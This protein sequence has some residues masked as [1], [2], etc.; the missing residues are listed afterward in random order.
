MGVVMFYHLTASGMEE[1]ARALLTRSLQA[2]WRVMLRGTDAA[3]LE[4]L[5]Q[6]LW[7]GPAESFLPHGL[8]GG[9]HDAQQPILLGTGAIANGAKALM[10]VEGAEVS[11]DEARGLERV[12]ILFNGHDDVAV[13]AAR[14][15]WKTLTGAGL[16]AQY[17][18]EENG[19][20][21]KKAG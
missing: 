18:S 6:I 15:Q 10:A 21:E 17:W 7:Q 2:G 16:A 8:A 5:D 12:F 9:P 14:V 19:S 20:W 3:G 13:A 1:T 4:R 11:L